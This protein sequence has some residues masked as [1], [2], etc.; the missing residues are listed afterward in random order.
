MGS[1]TYIVQY[2]KMSENDIRNIVD[3][4]TNETSLDVASKYFLRLRLHIERLKGF[5]ERNLPCRYFSFKKK[6]Y[7]CT[8]FE[9]TYIIAYFV[10][11]NRI[12]VKRII[13]GKRLA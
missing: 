11:G 3:Y 9:S 10:I 5:P 6:K 8:A 2:S 4:I 1:E 12:V 13:H 7:L